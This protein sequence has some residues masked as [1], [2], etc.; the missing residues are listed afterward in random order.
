MV[1]KIITYITYNIAH[2]NTI[3]SRRILAY[4]AVFSLTVLCGPYTV[5]ENAWTEIIHFTKK[6]Y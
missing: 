3:T 6:I 2:K 4:M 5:Q 1:I